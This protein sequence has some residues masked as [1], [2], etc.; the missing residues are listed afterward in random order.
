MQFLIAPNGYPKADDETDMMTS[1]AHLLMS[2]RYESLV[3]Y[4]MRNTVLLRHCI[5]EF[6]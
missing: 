3:R 1:N 6:M 4:F 5:V 2:C